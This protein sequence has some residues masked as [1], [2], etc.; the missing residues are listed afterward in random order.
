MKLTDKE[1]LLLDRER[2]ARLRDEY[3]EY[4]VKERVRLLDKLF[5]ASR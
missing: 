2:L 4:E 1:Q 5:A 3:H